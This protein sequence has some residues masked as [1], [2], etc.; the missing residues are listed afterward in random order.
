MRPAAQLRGI[1][2]QQIDRVPLWRAGDAGYAR[3]RIPALLTTQAGTVLAF[4]EARR[5]TGRDSDQIDLFL[6]R[7]TDCGRTFAAV[8]VV[9]SEPGWVSGN[10]APVQDRESGRIWL[11]FCRNR[12]DGDERL[13]CAGRAPRTVWATF[14]DDDALSWSAPTEITNQVKP[15]DWTWYA[16]GP[17]HGIQLQSSTSL[18]VC[19]ASPFR[20][21]AWIYTNASIKLSGGC[22]IL[23][24]L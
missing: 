2:I 21:L 1:P 22:C 14:S 12:E 9:T 24:P 17:C 10:P 3:Y 18:P 4:C 11:L 15:D 6:R 16:T 13:I 5:H 20:A 19:R 23:W 7:S 8:Q